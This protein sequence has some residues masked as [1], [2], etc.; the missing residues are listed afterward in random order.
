MGVAAA[1]LLIACQA[2]ATFS[3]SGAGTDPAVPPP[4]KVI[5]EGGGQPTS[6]LPRGSQTDPLVTGFGTKMPLTLVLKAIVP[7]RIKVR[8][9][10]G[11]DDSV[12]IS[13]K[14]NGVPWRDAVNLALQHTE[15]VV[16][17]ESPT[18]IVVEILAASR[19]NSAPSPAVATSPPPPPEKIWQAAS[20]ATL[21]ETLE[22]WGTDAGWTIDWRPTAMDRLFGAG[23]DFHGDFSKAA[24][25]LLG[26]YVTGPE[27]LRAKFYE[28]NHSLR[29]WRAG[30]EE[31]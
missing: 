22:K 17:D 20:G 28:G 12:L 7:A 27:A 4:Q 11:A 15:L 16:R 6:L 2:S 25:D 19:S 10:E 23:A 14:A 30:T 3:I 8:L 5:T 13:W 18:S 29:V 31:N 21:R 1:G 26:L 9:G 24:S